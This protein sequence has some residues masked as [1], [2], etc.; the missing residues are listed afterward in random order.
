MQNS[1]A[2]HHQCFT[3]HHHQLSFLEKIYLIFNST[4]S[5]IIVDD[6]MKDGLHTP[7]RSTQNLKHE[8]SYGQHHPN[9]LHLHNGVNW[10]MVKL[11]IIT[12]ITMPSK[13]NGMSF[14]LLETYLGEKTKIRS[15]TF[16]Y[17]GVLGEVNHGAHEGNINANV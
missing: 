11:V 10:K 5:C 9:Y 12:R 2:S 3:I 4:H 6:C 1:V 14:G 8:K 7:L 17:V 15:A 16:S 13:S